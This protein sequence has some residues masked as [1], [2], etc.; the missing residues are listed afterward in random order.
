MASPWQPGQLLFAGFAGTTLPE[1]LATLVGTGRVGGVVL[2]ARNVASPDQLR[3]LVAELHARAPVDA[4]LCVAIDQEGGRVQRLRAPW[5]EWPPMRRL[6]E[7]GSPADTQ[8]VAAA[9]GR[10]LA[11]LRIDLDFAPVADVDTN[12]ANP[13]IGDR[14]FSRDP[15]A[16]ARHA[17]AFTLGLQREGVAACAKHF[18]GH[19]DTT[20]D[21]HLELPRID[22]DRERLE[23]IE[24]VPFRAVAGA[25]VASM[26]TG[27]VWL[28]RIDARLPAT[29]SPAVLALLRDEI[30]YD[31]VVFSDDLEM[32]AIAGRFA[33][34]A[35]AHA[36]LAAGVDALLV[37]SRAELRDEVLAALEAAPDP[38]V[39]AGLGRMAAFKRRF[40]GGRGG[41]GGAPPYAAHREL[42]TRLA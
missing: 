3:E 15:D 28:P 12:P 29:L 20:V 38:L 26:M 8:A 14:S 41:S 7:R 31:G 33:P 27:H 22:H 5:T 2:F 25:G 11:D 36:A 17:V 34:A 35:V 23:R 40:A 10:E 21:S 9:L 16:V 4:P 30:G 13:V 6:G 1:D 37:C 39:E 32:R 42:A 24:L 19:G 18:P